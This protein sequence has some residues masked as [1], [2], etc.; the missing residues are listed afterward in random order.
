MP[1]SA[2]RKEGRRVEKLS[3]GSKSGTQMI[4]FIPEAMLWIKDFTQQSDE[5]AAALWP[6]CPPNWFEVIM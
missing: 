6:Q 2:S 3:P 5:W 4:G 1:A